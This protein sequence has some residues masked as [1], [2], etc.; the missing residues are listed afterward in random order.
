VITGP[1]FIRVVIA[2][3]LDITLQQSKSI[4]ANDSP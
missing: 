4:S 1:S 2:D 3:K